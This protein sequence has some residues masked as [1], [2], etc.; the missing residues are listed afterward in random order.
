MFKTNSARQNRLL[1]GHFFSRQWP[2]AGILGIVMAGVLLLSAPSVQANLSGSPSQGKETILQKVEALLH[3]AWASESDLAKAITLLKNGMA[4]FPNA[5][6]FPIYL[7]QAYYRAANP[8]QAVDKT[9]STYAKVG[10]YAQQALKMDSKQPEAHY[11]YGLYLL[12]KAQKI[13]GIRAFFVT[14]QAIRE[15]EEVRHTMPSYDYAGASRVLGLLY[16]LA[17]GWTPFGDLNKSIQL[18]KEAT[19]LAPNHAL[20]HLYL[21]NAYKKRGDKADAICQYRKLLALSS[22]L[23]GKDGRH[24]YQLARNNLQSLGVSCQPRHQI[25]MD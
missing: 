9:F 22:K 19:R 1:A 8:S 24:F 4:K 2:R 12:R 18:E 23:P 11:W 10:K 15:L 16:Y 20:N 25:A 3:N 14:R 21:A 13:G 7:A 5:I 17:P 6:Q